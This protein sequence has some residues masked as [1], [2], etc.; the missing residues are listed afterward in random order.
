MNITFKRY[1][2]I[3]LLFQTAALKSYAQLPDYQVQ[4]ISK[5]TGLPTSSQIR[6]IMKDD[7]GFL[8]M[9][10]ASKIQRFDGRNF[11]SFSFDD[12][13]VSITQDDEGIVWVATRQN[14][15]R[16]VNDHKGFEEIGGYLSQ[17]PV[18]RRMI[19]GPGKKLYLLSADGITRWNK[20]SKKFEPFGIKPLKSAGSFPALKSF[21]DC[22]FYKRNDSI[23]AR[24]NTVTAVEDHARVT[25]ANFIFPL[26][27]D[28][29][30]ARQYIGRSILV[31]FAAKTT[32]AINAS[33]VEGAGQGDH[34][35]I[36]GAIPRSP[37][38]Y[39]VLINNNGCF[40]YNTSK[41]TFKK[42]NFFYDGLLFP[43]K[44]VP[45]QNNFF[46]ENNGKVW[47]VN[48]EGLL[49]FNPSSYELNLFSSNGE[50]NNDIRNFAEDTQHNIWFSTANG[51][52]KWDKTSGK[53]SVWEPRYEA[54]NYL[55]YSSIRSIG[56][57]GNKVLIGQSE[58]GFWTFDPLTQ[59]FQRLP[60]KHDSLYAKFNRDFNHN[61]FKLRNG[62]FLALSN[63][64]WLIEKETF[65]VREIKLPDSAGASRSGYEDEQGRIWLAGRQGIFV[66]DSNFNELYSFPDRT[67]G[68]WYNAIVQ[69]DA[70][71]FWVAAKNIFEVKLRPNHKLDVRSI[72]PELGNVHFS[73]FFKDSLQRIWMS[74]EEG[75]YRYVPEKKLVEKFDRSDNIKSFYVSVS[76]SFRGSDGTV[77]FGSTDGINYFVPEKIPLQNDSLQIHL[78]NVT[79]NHDDSSYQLHHSFP[80]L[81]YSQ[82]A[83]VFDFI[84]P[85]VYNAE[86]I[87]YRCKLEGA[88]QNWISVGNNTSM[89]FTSLSPGKYKFYAAAS[90][91]GQDW[92]SLVTP[93]SFE[94]NP[95]F[96][97]T[98]WFILIVIASC[99]LLAIVLFR[100]RI[101]IIK[102]RA[103]VEQQLAGLE[104]R[105]LRSQMNPHFIFNS[106]NS[107]A[108]LVASRQNDEGLQYLNKFSKLLRLV[109]EE[110]ENSFISLKDEIKILDL[111]LQ[112]ESLRFGSSFSY[113]IHSDDG[114]DEEET[115]VPCFLIHPVIENAIWHGLLHK[116]G[117]R[118]L[119]IN[120]HQQEKDKLECVVKDNGIGIEA[121]SQKKAQ[122]L[123]GEKRQSKGLK[124]VKDR[125]ALME[126]QQQT[127]TAFRMEDMKDDNGF[128]SGTK[129][130]IQLPVQYE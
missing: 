21:G 7:K 25:D 96:W 52:C 76:N 61:G 109:L 37:D 23:L 26:N 62:N 108:Q 45:I 80:E 58:K 40:V 69:I 42:I 93:F 2:L 104:I 98:W 68:K 17:V 71:T 18:Y 39:L 13:C 83:L 35:F 47:V 123:N 77:Y 87:Q 53:V 118:R 119:I 72:F 57:S 56:F 116:E 54:D 10:L 44:P 100:R 130:T 110:S 126:Q 32:T 9:I 63:R 99:V 111:Y 95:P 89:R 50:W 29:V 90:L 105:A 3:L 5:K 103:A 14:I 65:N 129:V 74:N 66:L 101:A 78:L 11:L 114:I 33:Q 88:D 19:T 113:S 43:I 94:I 30:W 55:N 48:D 70:E 122:Q 24:F 73:H 27:S 121:A 92:Y 67:G 112:L 107:I 34:F 4:M 36:T 41:K 59:V 46:Q 51:F 127:T 60:V 79:V 106:L 125:L 97:K 22:L 120:F 6:D 85:Y 115:L 20:Q 12:V 117:E 84:A 8:W 38:E 28:S 128:I 86:K 15:Y 75:L 91:N 124:I 82:N 81:S 64:T 1:I 102:A 16:F 31:S 49:Y